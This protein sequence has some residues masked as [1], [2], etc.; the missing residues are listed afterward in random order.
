MQF[1]SLYTARGKRCYFNTI[2]LRKTLTCVLFLHA[3]ENIILLYNI[4]L[5]QRYS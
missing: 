3:L 5:K 4:I 1:D 2:D